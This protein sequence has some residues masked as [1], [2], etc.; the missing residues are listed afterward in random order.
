MFLTISTVLHVLTL[1]TAPTLFTTLTPYFFSILPAVK[2]KMNAVKLQLHGMPA[3]NSS[4]LEQQLLSGFLGGHH[5]QVPI[6]LRNWAGVSLS[7]LLPCVLISQSCCVSGCQE[8]LKS[9]TATAAPAASWRAYT[10][11]RT[12]V[13]RKVYEKQQQGLIHQKGWI[14]PQMRAIT[15]SCPDHRSY[16]T[17]AS[18]CHHVSPRT[19]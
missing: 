18:S 2:H 13:L 15:Q 4:Q 12:H 3:R 11:R 1:S 19:R 14:R 10:L 17:R 9:A 16:N 6:K 8:R 5:W 7:R